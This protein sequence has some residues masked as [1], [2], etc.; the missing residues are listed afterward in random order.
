MQSRDLIR[1][2]RRDRTSPE[3]WPRGQRSAHWGPEEPRG[4]RRLPYKRSRQARAQLRV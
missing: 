2:T 1:A 3:P 4:G